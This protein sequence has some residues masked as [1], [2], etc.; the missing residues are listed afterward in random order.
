M[1]AVLSPSKSR[2]A[3]PCRLV[4]PAYS[5]SHR[6]PAFLSELLPVVV[7]SPLEIR[8]CVVDDGSPEDDY[9][10]LDEKCAP[11]RERF[12]FL[13]EIHRLEENAGKGAAGYSGWDAA[14]EDAVWLGF[15]DADGAISP[16]EVVR[17][18]SLSVG[19][20]KLERAYFGSRI[21][22]LG[23]TV[24]RQ[25]WRHYGGRVFATLVS[26]TAGLPV[27]DSQCGVKI[28][29]AKVFRRIRDQLT[30]RRFCFD[31]DL[32]VELTDAGCEVVEVPIDWKHIPGS[33]F[34]Y[35]REAFRMISALW[36]IYKKRRSRRRQ[37]R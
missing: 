30:A 17:L 12:P 34:H 20:G 1:L 4:I 37:A 14:A 28:V 25:R 27:Y 9:R 16:A 2:P 18:F 33:S 3:A 15:V 36:R 21:R 31:V 6:L 32:L 5:E 13:L 7:D 23:K 29:P 19:E 10:R 24:E 22:M 35:G 11:L 26:I 8:V